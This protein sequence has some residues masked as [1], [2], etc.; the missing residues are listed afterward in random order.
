MQTGLPAEEDDINLLKTQ[1]EVSPERGTEFLNITAKH[2]SQEQAILIANAVAEAYTSRQVVIER[3]RTNQ[4][5]KILDEEI[6]LQIKSAHEKWLE[7]VA[8]CKQIGFDGPFFKDDP[9][10]LQDMEKA[11][12]DDQLKELEGE[13]NRTRNTF[14][15]FNAEVHEMR[16]KQQ[17]IRK[18]FKEPETFVSIHEYAR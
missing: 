3:E 2:Q 16:L 6:V 1:L 4:A 14:L 13:F 15:E 5:I 18:G 7:F 17:E 12:D 10:N 11:D 8:V 9:P